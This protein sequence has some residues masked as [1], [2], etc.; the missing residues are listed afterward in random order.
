MDCLECGLKFSTGK[1]LS[2]HL[3]RDDQMDGITYAIK[4]VYSGF[5]PMCLSCNLETRY[6]SYQ[7]KKNI[8]SLAQQ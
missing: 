7:F 2:N 4:H 5:R 6:S 3:K 8:V 1:I